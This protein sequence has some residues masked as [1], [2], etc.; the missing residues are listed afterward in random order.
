LPAGAAG[1][2]AAGEGREQAG[3]KDGRLAAA[4][5]ADDGEEAG[6]DQTGDELG[7]EPLATEE[8]V[9]ID[10]LE[11]GEALNG[12]MSSPTGGRERERSC[13][14]AIWRSVTVPASSDS[15]SLRLLR[16][17]AAREATSTSRRRAS[18]TATL[19]AA[20]ASSRPL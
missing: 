1:E 10:W 11:A 17:T 18:S 9:G 5:R 13:S 12:Q 2:D 8:V 7:D 3:A 6:T 20:P 16:P 4:G 14:R 19:S 15:T